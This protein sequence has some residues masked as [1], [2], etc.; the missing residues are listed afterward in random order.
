M[1]HAS[2]C[3]S[4]VA[5]AKGKFKI[6]DAAPLPSNNVAMPHLEVAVAECRAKL[7]VLGVTDRGLLQMP[8]T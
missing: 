8:K 7:K 2:L 1:H 4:Q 3:I 6:R 5:H